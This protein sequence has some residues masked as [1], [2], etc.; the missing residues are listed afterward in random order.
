MTVPVS[1][2]G[3]LRLQVCVATAAIP[4]LQRRNVKI[5]LANPLD[6]VTHQG[7]RRT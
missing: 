2:T 7:R 4:V 1:V 3:V 5:K 6:W